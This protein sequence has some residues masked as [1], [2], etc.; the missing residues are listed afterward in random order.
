[1]KIIVDA[2][3]GDKAPEEVVKGALNASNNPE[4]EIILVGDENKIK[5]HL[6]NSGK[7]IEIVHAQEVI[8]Y[9]EQPVT[10]IRKKKDSSIV[11]GLEMLKDKKAQAMVSAGSTGALMTGGLLILGR[12]EGIDRP[13]IGTL[14]PMAKG[15]I[16]MLDIGANSEVK[17]KN[18]VQFAVMGSIYSKEIL[19]KNNPAVGL[20]NIG[21]EEEKGNSVVKAAYSELKRIS[22]INFRGNIEARNIFDGDFDVVV[23]DGFTGN[24]FL[25]TAEG[26]GMYIFHQL[27]NEIKKSPRYL[28]GAALLKPAIEK[29]RSNMDYS[30]YGGAM[31][32][33]IDGVLVKCHG[34]SDSKAIENGINV[35]YNSV[36]SSINEKLSEG[37]KSVT[38]KGEI[39]K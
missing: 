23:C 34:S 20:L 13:A 11:R 30:E 37:L 18:L 2:M 32:L 7:N 14:C 16:L 3:G 35:A 25:K 31:F 26:F 5:P 4:I 27:K 6:N 38:K 9:D 12:L 8:T 10:A 19:N 17:P 15:P 29:I 36:I 24:I 22:S 33:G 39:V 21:T 28:A 1:M